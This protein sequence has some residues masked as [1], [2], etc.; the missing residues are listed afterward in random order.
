MDPGVAGGA[1]VNMRGH[2]VGVPSFGP[3]AGLGLNL[4]IGV[5]EVLVL[6]EQGVMSAATEVAFDGNP[7]DLLPTPTDVEGWQSAPEAPA[8]PTSGGTPAA[9]PAASVRLVHGDDTVGIGPFGELRAV[10][11]IA[12]DAEH[13]LWAWERALRRP[14]AGFIRLPDPALDATC[15]VYQRTG[16]E[17]V[18]V[19]V[20]CRES[21]V[22]VG[23]MLSGTSDVSTADT[24]VHAAGVM[25]QRVRDASRQQT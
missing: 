12:P 8:A 21:N 1:L 9:G 17:L 23:V 20:V 7:H 16:Q 24:A 13:G 5:E 4:A 15:H 22:V 10:A 3:D 18:D 14:P 2:V 19:R 6:L 11:L 25:I